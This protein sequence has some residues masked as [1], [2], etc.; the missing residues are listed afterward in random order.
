MARKLGA[1]YSR[2]ADDITLSF[3][4][5]DRKRIQYLIRFARRAA[6]D[7][8][9]RVRRKKLHIRRRHQQQRVTGLVVNARVQLPRATRRWLRAVE[10]HLR[11][12]RQATLTPAQLA[13]WRALQQMIATQR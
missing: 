9:Y 6:G 5:D 4:V 10:H 1:N 12:G 11:T 7:K 2:Y 13:G 3:A 8:G